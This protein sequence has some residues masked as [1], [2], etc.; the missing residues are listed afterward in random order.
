[1]KGKSTER[2]LVLTGLQPSA[3]VQL[4]NFLGAIR[5]WV[6]LQESMECLFFL[7][8]MHAITVPQEPD[9]LRTNTLDCVAM[10][11]ACGIDPE[12]SQIFIQSQV[13]GH[14]ELAWILA[15]STAIG[16][17][18]RMT[19]FKDKSAR[20]ESESVGAGLLYYPLLMA[21]DILLYDA[22]YV[23]TGEDQKQHVELT[24]DVA[25]HFN[26]R[27][28]PT[29]TVPKPLISNACARV[30][31]LQNP[32]AKMSK[33]DPNPLGVVFLTDSDAQIQKKFR[34]AVTDSGREVRALPEKP[35]ICNLLEILCGLTGEPVEELEVHYASASYAE[36]KGAVAAAAVAT[37]GPIREKFFE[38]RQKKDFLLAVLERGRKTAQEQALSTLSKVYRKV[39]F[40]E[41]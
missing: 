38:L 33:S 7:A 28:S 41:K 24:R 6:S 29:F 36:F 21:A 2:P 4:G 11:L 10:Y 22:D 9:Q 19:Q 25:E 17:L 12:K 15:C 8:D 35:G 5:S 40:L 20:K 23:P 34:S 37:I 18:E 13:F 1:M 31:S 27:Y 16:Q 14:A 32:F 26:R 3:G 30:M 39:G